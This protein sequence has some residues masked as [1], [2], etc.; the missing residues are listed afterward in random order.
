MTIRRPWSSPRALAISALVVIFAVLAAQSPGGAGVRRPALPQSF[1]ATGG[2]L[3]RVI[4][5]GS[6]PQGRA[7]ERAV[8]AAGGKVTRRLPIV[9]GVAAAVPR[10]ALAALAAFPGVAAVTPDAKLHAQAVPASEGET[11]VRSVYPQVVRADE[12]WQAGRTGVG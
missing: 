3:V 11:G 8:A 6:A 4:V 9:D 1:T 7:A 12:V 5:Q 10:A 2:G